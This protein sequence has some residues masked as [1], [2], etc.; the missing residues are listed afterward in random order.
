MS[1]VTANKVCR[2]QLLCLST[3]SFCGGRREV[4]FTETWALADGGRDCPMPV[5]VAVGQDEGWIVTSA[6]AHP[7]ML[8][9][10]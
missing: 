8:L 7:S 3:Q 10:E 1:C 9:Q 5:G 2:S 6:E 4:P